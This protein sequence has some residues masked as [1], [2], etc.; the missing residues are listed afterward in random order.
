MATEL[1]GSVDGWD[2]KAY[3]LGLLFY[4]YISEKISKYITEN[5]RASGLVNYNY[6]D[7]EDSNIDLEFKRSIIQELGY[8]IAPSE[9]F[10]NLKNNGRHSVELCKELDTVL[11]S[12]ERSAM[13]VGS[14]GNF[15][16]LFSDMDLNSTKLGNTPIERNKKL[17]SL[18]NGIAELKISGDSENIDVFGDAYEYLMG[19]YASNAGKSG[20]EYYTPPEVSELLTRLTVVGKDRVRRVYDPTCGSGSLL[21]KFI[22][23]KG[24]DFVEDG[25]FGQELNATTYNLC[26]INMFLHGMNYS[27]FDIK[28][29]NT[30]LEPMHDMEKPFDVIVSNPP[31]SI[32][33][34]Y[35]G[36]EVMLKE[37]PRFIEAGVLAP[38]SKGDLAFVLHALSYLS[39][40]GTAA[41]VCFPGVM[42]RGNAEQ[43]I[44]KYLVEG[45][46]VDSVIQLPS[47]L[48]Y[49]T[50]ISTCILVLK[51][52][53]LNTDITFID[54]S[55]E[56][57][58]V[59]NSNKLMSEHIDNIFEYYKGKVDKEY[60]VKV[61]TQD[62]VAENKY[63]LSVSK[64]V[65]SEDTREKI[66]ID[67]LNAEIKEI[68]AKQEILRKKIDEIIG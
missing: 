18:L 47:N 38:N 29:G 48:F 57:K 66:D 4:R 58:K 44:R 28:N 37:D 11:K 45:N 49:G 27:K 20:G 6:T 55:K 3:V 54:A 51:K 39:D 12:I 46:Y 52:N 2:F 67:K 36:R 43:K 56:F 10:E 59:T 7:L 31:Y 24:K 15:S 65:K 8:F 68:V 63:D 23:T 50:S 9:L 40:E 61:A 22:K 25:F 42:Y 32:K 60:I 34:W 14:E 53:K 19:M 35:Q 21:L 33:N 13:G 16:G 26:R 64:Y 17:L 1:R 41:I 62:V 5:E 30:L